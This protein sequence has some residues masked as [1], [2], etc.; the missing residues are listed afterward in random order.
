MSLGNIYPHEGRQTHKLVI[1]NITWDVLML[2]FENYVG[3]KERLSLAQPGN[4]GGLPE[5]LPNKEGPEEVAT[6]ENWGYN[7]YFFLSM[8]LSIVLDATL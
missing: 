7:A 5:K 4:V 3:T 8:C 1:S 6:V 2:S